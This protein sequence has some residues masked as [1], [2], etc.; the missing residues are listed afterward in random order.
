MSD[1]LQ[2]TQNKSHNVSNDQA[3]ALEDRAYRQAIVGAPLPI[4]IYAE[5]GEIVALSEGWTRLTGYSAEELATLDDWVQRAYGQRSADILEGINQLFK[6]NQT[7]DEGEFT[8][9]TKSG[10][11]RIWQFSS[12]P[13]GQLVDGRRL[14][15]SM[16]A[17]VTALKAS[18]KQVSQLN[19]A[20]E[21]RV[22]QRTAQLT[23]VN[24][25]LEAFTY[26]VSHDLR[27][28][29][30]AMEGFAKALLEDYAPK[31][32]NV[33]G[34]YARRIV[35]AA[36]R[37]DTLISDLL[38][39][40]R[41]SRTHISLQP[42]ELR[43]IIEQICQELNPL[44]QTAQAQIIIAN[45]LPQVLGNRYIIKQIFTNLLT[46]S[47]KFVEPSTL[48]VIAVSCEETPDNVRI[49]VSDNGLGIA[50]KHQQR[51]FSV[52]ERLHSNETYPGTGVGLAIVKRGVQKI[53]GDAGVESA[54]G[55]GSQF[56][57]ELVKIK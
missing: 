43:Q 41:I 33:A 17:D 29:L 7:V 4:L 8:L 55:Q 50:A 16:A 32:D 13:L 39:Y 10:D 3:S 48:P 12:S 35:A 28:P 1:G 44:I 47:L 15:M 51:I 54:V 38:A 14:V 22:V 49:W 18:E 30:R 40:S 21:E 46:N 56:W 36:T 53:G 25:E 37:M 24:Q 2:T 52:F 20:L 23:A 57:V 5:D 42:I 19:Q 26:T 34:D 31:M 11:Q 27:A 6:L 45:E 9:T